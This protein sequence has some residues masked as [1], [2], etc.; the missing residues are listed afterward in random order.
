M[1]DE[2]CTSQAHS[3][4][5][6]R[7]AAVLAAASLT[8]AACGSETDTQ[9]TVGD[10]EYGASIDEWAEATDSGPE[11]ATESGSNAQT[12]NDYPE[13]YD[14]LA[15]E[16]LFPA[17]YSDDDIYARYEDRLAALEDGSPESDAIYA[18]MQAEYEA[19][20]DAV[21]LELDGKKVNLAGFVAPLDYQAEN[22][23]EFLLV[24]YFGACIHVPAPPPNQTILVTVDEANGIDVDDSWGAIWV[25]GTLT[26][27]PVTTDLA[28][29]SYTMTDATAG[30]Y[31]ESG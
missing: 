2:T 12:V 8:V 5:W 29:A 17:G 28:T 3:P 23:T 9:E 11:A 27:D 31:E 7:T 18:E 15:W 19:N 25:A 4:R 10:V 14:E 16:D 1:A 30:V 13:G 6:R 24:P 22:I 26:V 21:N 20:S